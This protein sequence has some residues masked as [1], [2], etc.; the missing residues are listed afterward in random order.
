MNKRLPE[1]DGVRGI[2]ILLVFVW[3]YIAIQIQTAAG[4]PADYFRRSLGLTWSGVDLFFVLSGFLIVGILLDARGKAH[5]FRT[6]Y[7]RRIC[8]I[9]PLYL[10]MVGVFAVIVRF[11]LYENTFL[12]EEKLP[13]W[14]Y[15]TLTQ[16]FFMHRNGF[17][18]NWLGVTWSLA[19][20]EQFYLV[21]PL[22]VYLL[23][24]RRLALFFGLAILAAPMLRL[25]IGN[26]GAYVFPFT[27]GDSILLGGLLAIATR[28]AWL[29]EQLEQHHRELLAVFV[30]L[31]LG[32]GVLTFRLREIGNAFNHFWL[33]LL[34]GAFVLIAIQQRDDLIGRLLRSR[35]L[36]WFGTRSYGIYLFHQPISG[37][38][39]Q[40]TGDLIPS[41]DSW[42][43]FLPT[44]ASFLLV[45]ALAEISFRYFETPFLEIGHRFKYNQ[46]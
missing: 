28:D 38:V 30:V 1:L 10:L 21:I 4:T 5:Y 33:A 16:N 8:R 6:F 44:L 29:R 42:Q 13:L 46:P 25:V 12:F 2:A 23:D 36:V 18:P 9:L 40:M 34:Y 35:P 11:D 22:I 45:I 37:L 19:I 17:G 31:L 24:R 15:F 43:T 7:I 3:H 32:A 39:H 41:F 26:Y 20:E 14:S 27:R